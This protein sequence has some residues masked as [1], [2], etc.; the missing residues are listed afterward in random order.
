MSTNELRMVSILG[1]HSP[2]SFKHVSFG[3]LFLDSHL[4]TYHSNIGVQMNG[5][6]NIGMSTLELSFWPQNK[7]CQKEQGYPI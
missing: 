2:I 5:I 7:H 4:T 1:T 3:C 6:L